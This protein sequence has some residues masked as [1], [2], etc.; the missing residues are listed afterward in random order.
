MSDLPKLVTAVPGPKSEDWISRSK[1]AEAGSTKR[2]FPVVWHKTEGVMVEDVDGNQFL[3]FTAANYNASIGY[4]HPKLTTALK[5]Q[6]GLAVHAYNFTNE[7]RVQLA[8]KL[9][10]L[11]PPHLDR[12]FL[13]TTGAEAVELVI[14]AAKQATGKEEVVGMWAGYHGKTY[15]T[16]HYA[17]KASSRKRV[18]PSLPGA[19]HTPFPYAYR[20]PFG[21][22]QA[23]NCDLHCFEFFLRLL[24]VEG[25]KNIAAVITEVFLGSGGQIEPQGDFLRLMRQW[26]DEHD[27]VLIFDEV[28]TSFGRTGKWFAFEHFDVIPDLMTAGKGI[29]SGFPLTSIIGTSKVLDNLGEGALSST[30]GGN[31]FA[32][33]AAV[34]TIKIME[35]EHLIDRS[36]KLG[37]LFMTELK[38][39][40][41]A[42]PIVGEVRGHGLM[43]GIEIVEDKESRTPAKELAKKIVEASIKNGLMLIK[44]IG[45]Y[46]NVV[47]MA[48]AFTLTED[49]VRTGL[50][51]FADA[52]ASVA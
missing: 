34:E 17:G 37:E 15:A 35:E 9:V 18:G 7:W 36:A 40:E 38:K 13:V 16:L 8:E 14:N 49:Q 4:Q 32:C 26:C 48:P 2:Q 46:G 10:E 25:T 39:I 12:A 27:A 42:S 22:R 41:A 30:H 43:I 28:Q 6:L 29:S 21:A 50:K 20:C 5:E 45:F 44:P 51:I 1:K 11:T 3:D 19:I 52:V 23:H 24:E 47:R 31:P 33:R